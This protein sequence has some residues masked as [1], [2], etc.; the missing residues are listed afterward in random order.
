M[1]VNPYETK[2]NKLHW[3][4]EVTRRQFIGIIGTFVSLGALLFGGFESLK[5]LFPNSTSDPPLRFIVP[6]DPSSVTVDNPY[7]DYQ[8]RVG[9]IR[10][11]GGFYCV[12]LVCTHLGCTPNY[13]SNCVTNTPVA[14]TTAESHGERT[15][16]ERIPN[17]WIC[18]CHGS[19]YFIDSTNFYGPAPR[20]MDWVNIEFTPDKKQFI[21]DRSNIV[22]YRN[23]GQV[24]PPLWR[25]DAT[26]GVWNGKVL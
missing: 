20:P 6:I 17:G 25:I 3:L 23:P 10:D 2:E 8:H 16:A 24:T 12:Q 11:D 18:P 5:F 13:Y 15:P 21:V 26:T 9:I 19:R 14:P 22:V 7:M 4:A 1:S